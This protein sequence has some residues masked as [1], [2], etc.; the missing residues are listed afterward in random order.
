MKKASSHKTLSKAEYETLASFRCAVRKVLNDGDEAARKIG[1]TPQQNQA[2][3]AIRGFPGREY[4]TVGELAEWLQIRHHSAVGLV[5][6]LESLGYVKRRQSTED[7]RTVHVQLTARGQ[8]VLNRLTPAYRE[9]LRL[10]GRDLR[11][12]IESIVTD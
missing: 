11:Q 2:L 10:T 1:I 8:S 5:D 4:V 7:R 12:L 6:R 9:E 3:L